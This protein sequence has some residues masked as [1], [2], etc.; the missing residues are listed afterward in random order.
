MN[1]N[2]YLNH[3]F[4]LNASRD[5]IPF[6]HGCQRGSAKEVTESFA[7]YYA[8]LEFFGKEYIDYSHVVV[9]GDGATPRTAAT[10][11]FLSKAKTYSVDPI[12]RDNYIKWYN[13]QFDITIS[14]INTF[15]CKAKDMS[16]DMDRKNVL[17]VLPHS[18]CPMD[19]AI[20]MIKFPKKLSCV[21]M[22]C[23]V[24]VSQEMKM[25]ADKHYVDDE[26]WSPKNEVYIWE[27]LL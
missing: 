16:L 8:A 13:S 22:P 20:K 6:F 7:C 14:R 27:S 4:S 21:N 26:V 3:F 19:E 18:H 24:N 1:H 9:I 17:L 2:R 11:A 15:K 23:C 10:F 25:K 12:L 5:L